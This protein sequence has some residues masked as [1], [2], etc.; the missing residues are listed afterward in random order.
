[1]QL[2]YL[3]EL[4]DALRSF[5][6]RGVWSPRLGRNGYDRCAPE[7]GTETGSLRSPSASGAA[8]GP[9]AMEAS[10][11]ALP[12]GPQWGRHAPAR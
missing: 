6:F 5:R 1:M 2:T 8:G 4:R 11:P 9:S 10:V 12:E 3:D 7:P